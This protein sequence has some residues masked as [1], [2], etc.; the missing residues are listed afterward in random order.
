MRIDVVFDVDPFARDAVARLDQAQAAL[1]ASLKKFSQPAPEEDEEE[2]A[3]PP[4]DYSDAKILALGSTASIRDLKLST[5]RDQIRINVFVSIAV[6]LV[7]MLL[8][9]QPLLCAYLIL[10]V[11]FSYLVTLGAAYL[12]FWFLSTDTEFVGLDWKVP[13]YLFTLL[14]A[15]GEDY[16]VLFMSRV[17]EEQPKHGAIPGILLALTKTGGIISSC[18]IIMAGTF[19]SLMTGTL[20]GMVQLGFALAFG[21]LI[22]TF[23]VR[24]I[25]VPS[26]L[27]LLN[28][29]TFG[30]LSKLLGAYQP[31]ADETPI[32]VK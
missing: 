2:A 20:A 14:L 1:K 10:T 26:Y 11:I 27:V 25:L 22:D 5:D 16:N 30:R 24:P 13:V 6:F 32:A 12:L 21:V 8:L 18:G 9:R 19:A 15:L 7:L 31:K 23:I 17:T 28:N 3:P 29:G 4:Q